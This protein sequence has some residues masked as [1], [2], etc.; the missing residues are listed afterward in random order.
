M[1]NYL[2]FCMLVGSLQGYDGC[3]SCNRFQVGPH[4][5]YGNLKFAQEP[6]RT[7]FVGGIAALFNHYQENGFYT[8]LY[9]RGSWNWGKLCDNLNQRSDFSD[10]LAETRTGLLINFCDSFVVFFVG[11]G[12]NH[13]RIRQQPDQSLFRYSKIYLPIGFYGLYQINDCFSIGARFKVKPDLHPILTLGSSCDRMP[14]TDRFFKITYRYGIDVELPMTYYFNCDC[15]TGIVS[16]VRGA[17][18]WYVHYRQSGLYNDVYFRGSWSGKLEDCNDNESRFA[19]YLAEARAGYV[20]DF[21]PSSFVVF[22]AGLGYN[23]L[24]IRQDN[25]DDT[26]QRFHYNKLYIPIGIYSLWQINDCF[27]LGARV[28]VKP[29]VHPILSVDPALN[30]AT[31]ETF[32]ILDYRYGIDIQIPLTYYFSCNCVSGLISLI[33]YLDWNIYGKTLFSSDICSLRRVLTGAQLVV[34]IEY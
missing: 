21:C 14:T 4:F 27:S 5:S 18:A 23:R 7:G 11:L 28:K 3:Y 1:K 26:Q 29:Y 17:S 20:Y 30:V 2:L 32:L 22:F 9:F 8:D 12:F 10:Y 25:D 16:L 24:R 33:P 6:S 31:A 19:D 34:G 13:L 15:I